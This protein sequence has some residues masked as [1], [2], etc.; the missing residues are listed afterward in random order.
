MYEG[1]NTRF[2]IAKDEIEKI[3]DNWDVITGIIKEEIRKP[4]YTFEQIHFYIMS[5]RDVDTDT[6]KGRK[7]LVD[8]FVNSIVVYDDKILINLNYKKRSKQISF[9]EIENSGLSSGSMSCLGP[10]K[11]K[12]FREC[13][14]F[15]VLKV[16]M[17]I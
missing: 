3:I 17:K 14:V 13:L 11:D 2:D 5:F 4:T 9:K 10:K 7:T 16:D 1:E 15:F 8:H 12:V 6:L